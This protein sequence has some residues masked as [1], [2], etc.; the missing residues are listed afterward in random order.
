M[1]NFI[2][3]FTEITSWQKQNYVNTGGTRAKFVS[4]NEVGDIYYFKGSK[5]TA[6]GDVRYPLE[7]WSEILSSKIGQLL[8]FNMLDYNIGY[9]SN[10]KQKIGCLSKSMIDEKQERL[11]EGI[12][13]LKGFS[14][15]YQPKTDKKKYTFQFISDAL[16]HHNIDSHL[17]Y[18]ID[19]II[20][21]SIVGNSDRHQENW[22]F[23]RKYI[24]IV[25]DDLIQ[26]TEELNKVLEKIKNIF[27]T[28]KKEDI[29]VS[30]EVKPITKKI[31]NPNTSVFSPI[32]DSGCCLARE[33]SD[34]EI[35]KM[36]QDNQ[37]IEKYI[38]RGKSEIHW[39][40][41]KITHFQLIQNLLEC[42]EAT[43][44]SRLILIKERYNRDNL[45][46]L[47][48]NIDQ[49]LPDFCSEY[50]IKKERKEVIIKIVN[51]RIDKLLSLL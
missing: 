32:Y 28:K 29:K 10:H 13:Y 8:G 6:E 22:G 49:S 37:E 34:D 18:L 47:V 16:I 7:F 3:T 48:N 20:F 5:E 17:P 1:N 26:K 36:N 45:I 30:V 27:S 15:E 14:P 9:D 24:E 11:T 39:E 38:N 2:P 50:K 31:I 42:H 21:D 33:K 12:T 41:K 46:S 44:K 40:E 19:I 51:L 25:T 23:I 4:L 43:V 35:I